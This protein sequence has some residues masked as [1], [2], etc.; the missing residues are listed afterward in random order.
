VTS[1]Q[2]R[3]HTFSSLTEL[4]YS[5]K[6]QIQR[7]YEELEKTILPSY[8]SSTK[9]VENKIKSL[10]K[11]YGKLTA[12]VVQHGNEWHAEVDRVVEE[13]KRE[14]DD[15]K[16]KHLKLLEDILSQMKHLQSLVH[17]GKSDALNVLDS[18]HVSS[19][20]GYLSKNDELNKLP[21]SLDMSV[22][23]FLA[24][25]IDH[26]QFVTVFGRLVSSEK[27]HDHT[28]RSEGTITSS[29]VKQLLD[30]Q[31]MITAID[32]SYKPLISVYCVSKEEIWV[33][34]LSDKIECFL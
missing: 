1:P 27:E 8:D 12:S 4:F 28:R 22:P 10:D 31:K 32:T 14:I 20:M 11:E 29:A 13:V 9:E 26:A 23:T 17:Q 6:Q 34:G 30:K 24:D 3:G 5:K 33:C 16:R 7:D 15:R 19:V 25:N 18:N 21:T 2:H